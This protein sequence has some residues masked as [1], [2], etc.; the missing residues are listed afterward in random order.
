MRKNDNEDKKLDKL[1]KDSISKGGHPIIPFNF[2]D[3]MTKRF[4]LHQQRKQIWNEWGMKLMV[5]FGA[6]FIFMATLFYT[7]KDIVREVISS[8]SIA[9]FVLAI[10]FFVFFIDQVLLK[11]LF[12]ITR[13]KRRTSNK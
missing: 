10:I 4:E 1:I 7:E 11:L 12:A 8:Y 9:L 13:S 3:K 5:I 6:M 2:V